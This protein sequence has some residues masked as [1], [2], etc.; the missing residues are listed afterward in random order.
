MLSMNRKASIMNLQKTE[1]EIVHSAY[2]HL[3]EQMQTKRLA[4]RLY[5][6]TRQSPRINVK[7]VSSKHI[8]SSL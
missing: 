3:W 1:V 8:V 4:Q 7:K 6:S 2:H 5:G